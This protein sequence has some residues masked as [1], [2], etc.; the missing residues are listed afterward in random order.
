MNWRTTIISLLAIPISLLVS[1]IIL[2]W[3]GYTINTMSLG[4]M[5]IA[6]GALVD[7][8]IIDVENVYKRLR[9]NI[10]KPKAERE[11]TITVVRDASVEIRSSIIIATLIIIVSFIPL[12]F[13]SGMEGRLLQPLGIAFV[14][15]VL[16]SLI[17]AVTVTPILCSYLLN[18]EKLLNKQKVQKW[19]V[20]YRN[21]MATSWNVP[22]KFQKL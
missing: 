18:N 21:I 1:I 8:A 14:T 3:L 17:V 4:G 12:F 20:G 10:R 5:A 19:N 13:L 16:T 7:D 22:L 9:E 2:K 6:I 11:S 15:S